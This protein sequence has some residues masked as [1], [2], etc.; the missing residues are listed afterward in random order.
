[1]PE[2]IH[3]QQTGGAAAYDYGDISQPPSVT[4]RHYSDMNREQQAQLVEDYWAVTNGGVAEK[5][6]TKETLEPYIVEEKAGK[7]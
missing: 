3:A 6:G 1:M 5:S 2:A 4:G 7:F